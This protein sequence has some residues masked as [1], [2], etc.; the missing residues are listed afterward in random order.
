MGVDRILTSGQQEKAVNGID[1]LFELQHI[2]DKKII[3][4]PGS[5]INAENCSLFKKANFKEIHTSASKV[6]ENTDDSYFGN[7]Q[8]TVS[9]I[10]TIKEIFKT[11]NN[12]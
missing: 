9:D 3:I 11:M 2:A 10:E 6:I 7:I 8:Q 1:L 4:M 5:G 12:A